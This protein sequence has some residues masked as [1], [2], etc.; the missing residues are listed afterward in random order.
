MIGV[1]IG[2]VVIGGGV[3]CMTG[4]L[5]DWATTSRKAALYSGGGAVA[6]GGITLIILGNHRRSAK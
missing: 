5:H 2:M 1:G 4:I 6:A 3:I